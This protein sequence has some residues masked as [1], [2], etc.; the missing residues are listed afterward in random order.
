MG[1]QAA[2]AWL[3]SKADLAEGETMDGSFANDTLLT[4]TKKK[5]Q[6]MSPTSSRGSVRDYN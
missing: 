6:F 4:S 5:R 1:T 3:K 2:E